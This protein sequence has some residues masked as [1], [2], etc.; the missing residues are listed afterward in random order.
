VRRAMGY[1]VREG[2]ENLARTLRQAR[3]TLIAIL[4]A[5]LVPGTA[6]AATATANLGSTPVGGESAPEVVTC[7][8]AVQAVSDPGSPSY[9]APATGT[10]TSWSVQGMTETIHGSFLPST[11]QLQVYR[12]DGA[13]WILV[14][15]SAQHVAPA[16]Q[17]STFTTSVP[18][19]KGDILGLRSSIGC[20]YTS[21]LA[22]DTVASFSSHPPVGTSLMLDNAP[23]G[24]ARLNLSAVEQYQVPDNGGGGGNAGGDDGDGEDQEDD[25]DSSDRANHGNNGHQVAA[26]TKHGKKKRHGKCR[27][28]GHGKS[29]QR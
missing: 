19:Q 28:R 14:A 9:V 26:C 24:F 12:P 11:V 7:F 18:V 27:G 6:S 10:I 22:G 17:L 3:A 13:S 4:F 1:A 2:T 16:Q 20:T 21:V 5:A 29:K 8:S 25:V 15:E 23:L